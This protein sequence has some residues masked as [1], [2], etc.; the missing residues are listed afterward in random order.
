M[1]KNSND[2]VIHSNIS[3]Q[4]R[5]LENFKKSNVRNNVMI[6]RE[7]PANAHVFRRE[8][9]HMKDFKNSL[10]CSQHKQDLQKLPHAPGNSLFDTDLVL[11]H[12]NMSQ[13]RVSKV[14][15]SRSH[16][17]KATK[18]RSNTKSYPEPKVIG[19]LLEFI[20]A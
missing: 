4:S 16:I 19:T 13:E 3:H 7:S 15:E 20:Y 9:M 6:I 11:C 1:W 8:K 18:I 5:S 14:Y 10:R 12:N 17:S 2:D